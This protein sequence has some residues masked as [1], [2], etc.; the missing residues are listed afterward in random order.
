MANETGSEISFQAAANVAR[1][2]EMV[3]AQGGQGSDK[4][5]CHSS[6]FSGASSRGKDTFGRGHPPKLFHSA[7]QASHGASGGRGPQ[8]HYFDQLAY[9]APPAPISAPPL[10]SYQGGYS[11]RQGQFQGQQS[12]Q[13]RLCYTCGDPRHIARFCPRATGNSHHQSSR[14]MVPAP[15]AATPA[16]PARGRGQAARGRGQIV[17]GR[18]QAIRGGD[19]LARGRPRDVVQGG[20]VQPRCYAFPSR[21]EAES[22][23]AVITDFGTGSG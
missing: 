20:G 6:E 9:S 17:R 8:I 19:Q 3:L 16:Q 18:G 7:L 22:S 1:R 21:H 5:P 2:V 10:Q 12:Q 13:P 23:D 14:A 15:V 11:G 4:R